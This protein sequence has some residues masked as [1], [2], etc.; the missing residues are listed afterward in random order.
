MTKNKYDSFVVFDKGIKLPYVDKI[1]YGFVYDIDEA[2]YEISDQ[3]THRYIEYL[4]GII[5]WCA[6]GGTTSEDA[7]IWYKDGNT[8]SPFLVKGGYISSKYLPESYAL[9]P[10]DYKIIHGKVLYLGRMIWNT[11]LLL[12]TLLMSSGRNR[13]N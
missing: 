7:S 5:R 6:E 10:I 11:S 8:Y 2:T 1:V 9:N 13:T 3:R 12:R 4:A